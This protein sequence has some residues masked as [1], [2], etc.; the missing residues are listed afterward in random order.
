M[1]RLIRSLAGG[2]LTGALLCLANPSQ[3]ALIAQ[4][5]LEEGSID[6]TTNTTY[7]A[8]GLYT[9]TLTGAPAPTWLTN[10]LPPLLVAQGGTTAAITNGTIGGYVATTFWGTN[11]SGSSSVLG[12][13]AR[14]VTAWVR[15]PVA[16]SASA[17][18]Y[19]V[20]YGSGSTI[21]GGRFSLR[22]DTT[23]GNTFGKLR[24]EVSSGSVTGTNAVIVDNNWHHLAVVCQAGCRMTNVLLYVDGNLQQNTTTTPTILINTATNFNPVQIANSALGLST[25]TFLGSVDDVRIYDTALTAAQIAALVFGPGNPPGITQ[26]PSAQ[27][28]YLGATNASATFNVGVSGSPTILYQWKKNGINIS[29]ATSQSYSISP[30]TSANLAAYSVGITNSYGGTNSASASLSWSTPPVD[31]VEETVLVGSNASFSVTMP[32]DS[33]GYSYQWQKGGVPIGGATASNYTLNNAQLTDSANYAVAVTLAGQSATSAPVPLHVLSVPSSFY[34]QF[35]LRDGPSAYWRLGEANGATV[36]TDVT[37]FHSG[38]YSNYTGVELQQPGG[39]TNDADTASSFTGGNWVEVPYTTAALQHNTAFT[40][41]AW[42]NP[43]SASGTQA[44]LCSRN[45]EFSSGYELAIN[46]TSYRFRTG[47]STSPASEIWTDLSAGTVAVGVWQHVVASFD[48]TTKRLYV[49]GVLV[50]SQVTTVLATPV[51]ARIGA[52]LTYLTAPGNYFSGMIDDAAI[53]WK[54]LTADQIADHYLA[55]TMGSGVPVTIT[56]QPTNQL[57]TLGDTNATVSFTVS[58]SGSPHIGYQW[59]RSGIDQAGQTSSTLTIASAGTA[60]QASY[61]VGVSNGSGGLLGGPATLSYSTAPIAPSGLALLTGGS[62]SFSVTMPS[63]QTYTYQWKHTGTNLPGATTSTLTINNAS[64]ANAGSYT[65]VATL[66]PDSAESAAA[67]LTVIPPP[68]ISYGQTISNDSPFAWLRLDDAPSSTTAADVFGANNGSVFTYANDVTFGT[69]GALLGDSDTSAQFTG[70]NAYSGSVRSGSGKI[71]VGYSTALNSSN[72]TAECWAMPTAG[73]GTTRSPLANIY[74]AS[75]QGFVFYALGN[76]WEVQIGTGTSLA[77]LTGP[78]VVEN[79]WAHLVCTYNG[80]TASFYV[81]G[82][83]VATRTLAYEPNSLYPLN[84]GA[85]ANDTTSGNYYFP[86][87]I[88]EVAFYTNALTLTQVQAHYA[89]AFP[90]N[91]APRLTYQPRSRATLI[92]ENYTLAAAV[93][94]PAPI[95]YQWKHAGTNLPGA[96]NDSLLVSSVKATDA[97]TYQLQTTRGTGT[98]SSATATLTVLPGESVSGSLNGNSTATVAS[99]G[100]RAGFVNVGNWNEMEYGSLAGT[101]TNLVNNKGQTNS[102]MAA[103]SSSNYRAWSGPLQSTAGDTTML[104]GFLDTSTTGSSTLVISN[105]PASYQSGGYS[106][107]VYMGAPYFAS[108]IVGASDSFGAISVGTTTNFYHAIDLTLWDGSYHQATDTNPADPS[109]ADANYMVFTGLNSASVTV[110]ATSHPTLTGPGSIS[111]FQLVA[112]VA[113][114]TPVPIA[115]AWQGNNLVLTWTGTWVLQHSDTPSGVPNGWH[116]VNGASSPYTIP[117]PLTTGQYYRLRSP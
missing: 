11:A 72:F 40:L 1:K 13:N 42:V 35:V 54:G 33:T 92:G 90:Q 29:G 76:I 64:A 86:G 41:E 85:G 77:T 102:V 114:V 62:G 57:V 69:E 98:A 51:P 61:T 55:G 108:G 88:D 30:V 8:D 15:T 83:L 5:S 81:N 68:A 67:T 89:A 104:N 31:P 56:A 110:V 79:Q 112:N 36:A 94:G 17:A 65:V 49:N 2:L 78:A 107:Y 99:S 117:Q 3:A 37:G 116:D 105:I 106:L 43:S 97:G 71:Q 80:T 24:L 59:K 63:Y 103:W 16:P 10:G 9:G 82:S 22:L 21:V 113:S 75:F 38:S 23:A 60:G 73:A 109:P 91:A 50:G 66:G 70:Y 25:S 4:F 27:S 87:R 12:T 93:H 20:S 115:I 28:A 7:T 53:Y 84:I 74:S 100:G 14:T 52:G 58:A 101:R 19:I 47:N 26:Q 45:K 32:T 6:T 96:T 111:G 34:S 44:I 18:A 48:G 46:G 95:T 39:L